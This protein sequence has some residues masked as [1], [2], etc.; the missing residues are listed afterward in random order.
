[1]TYAIVQ[2]S[3]YVTTLG[4]RGTGDEETS[5]EKL[6]NRDRKKETKVRRQ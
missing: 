4:R 2:K 6:E 1:M 5:T 3:T